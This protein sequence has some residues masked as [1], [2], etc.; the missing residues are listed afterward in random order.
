MYWPHYFLQT[1][2]VARALAPG[3]YFLFAYSTF[4]V[5]ATNHNLTQR[6]LTPLSS[7]K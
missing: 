5:T 6:L 3:I 4:A 7:V 1:S 2:T